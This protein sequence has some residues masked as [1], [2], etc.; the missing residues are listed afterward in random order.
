MAAHTARRWLLGGLFLVALSTALSDIVAP[1]G[2]S[3]ADPPVPVVGITVPGSP[4]IGQSVGIDITFVNGSGS[5][6]GYGPYVDLRLPM[7]AD[8]DDGLTFTDA[9]YLGATVV[10]VQ[11]V[12]DAFG[13]VTHPW[14]VDGSGPIQVCGMDPGQSFVALRLPFGSFTPGQPTATLH[15]TAQLSDEADAGT[16]L[17]VTASGGFQYGKDP[18]D[19]P[20]TDPSITGSPDSADLSPTVIRVQKRYN[21]PEGE[22]ATGPNFPRSY[23]I[24]ATI[25]RDQTVDDLILADTLPDNMQF[26]SIDTPTDP[27]SS[28]VSTPSLTVPGGTLSRNFG[29]VVGTGGTDA[30]FTFY[31]Y[32]PRLDAASADVLPPD[33]GAFDTSIDSVRADATW[34]PLDIRDD[35]GPVSAG[36]VTHTLTDKSVAIQ[37]SVRLATDIG[38]AGVSPGDTLE[39]TLRIQ[40]SDYFALR[41]VVVYDRLGDGTRWDTTAPTLTVAGNGFNSGSG[42]MD[43]DNYTV[44]AVEP[45]PSGVTPMTF[46]LS[47]ELIT[48][49]QDGR[50]V[51]GCVDPDD[52][53]A[54]PDCAPGYDDGPTEATIVFSSIVQRTY[55]DGTT[56][57]V[58]GDTLANLASVVGEVL[59]TGDFAPTGNS[60]GDGSVAV[61]SA[62]TSASIPIERGSLEKSIYAIN[63]NTS[64]PTPVHVAPGDTITYE[65]KQTFPTSRTDDFRM[66]DYLPLPIFDATTV[67]AFDP[68]F[69]DPFDPTAPPSGTAKYGPD[70]TFHAL[71]GA[72][73]PT[74]SSDATAN[75]VQFFYGDYALYPSA[76]STVD[77]LFTITVSDDPFADGLLLTNQARSQTRNSAGDLQTADAI[78]QITLDQPVLAITKGVVATSRGGA[79]LAPATTGPVT[80]STP[81]GATCPAWSDGPVTSAGL[82]AHPVDSD[83]S[84][85]DA[86]D[87][88]RFAIVVE[89]TGHSDAYEVQ[90]A[91]SLPA[92]LA[93]PGS[94]L[95]L[96]VT[97]GAGT[98]I[99]TTNIG[100]GGLLDQGIQLVDGASGALSPGVSGGTPNATGTNIVVV[101]FTLQIAGTAVPDTTISNTASLLGYANAP[102]EE[103]HLAAP[104]TDD[105]SV[106]TLAPAIGKHV[107]AA[108]MGDPDPTNVSVGEIVTY[109]TTVTIPEG[110]TPDATVTDTLPS[111][112]ALLDCVSI[113][114]SSGDVTTDLAGGFAEACNAGTNPTVGA[115]G[116]L[117]TFD[118]GTIT[119]ANADNGTPETIAIRYRTVVLNTAD[120][121]AGTPLHNSAAFSWAG[122]AIDPVSAEELVVMEPAVTVGKSADDS[123]AD[124]GDT[125]TY[126]IT[127]T[128]V[129]LPNVANAFEVAWADSVPVGET[130]VPGSLHLASGLPV[131]TISAAA[132]PDLSATWD[133]FP[134]GSSA[135]LEYQ[136]TVDATATPGDTYT[137]V[138]Q[139][140]WTSYPGDVTSPQSTFSGVSTERTGD[141]GDPGGAVNDYRA[142]DDWDVDVPLATASKSITDTDQAHTSGYNVAVGEIVTYE[143]VLTLPEGVQPLAKLTD[144][145]PAGMALVDCVSI[146]R[147]STDVSTDLVGGF[148]EACDAGTSPTV[149]A[150]GQLVTFDLGT[151][152]NANR[153]NGTAETLTLTY[154]AV[155]LN[156]G[157]NVRGQ[158]LHNSAVL[159]WTGGTAAT[160]SAPNATVVEPTMV[161]VKSAN[162]GNGDA[163]DEITFTITITNP[164]ATNGADA[165]DVVWS[166]TIPDGLT[167][168]PGSLQRTAGIVP[169]TLAASAPDLSATWDTFAQNGT[170]TLEYKATLDADVPSG[171]SYTNTATLTWTSLPGDTT[172]PLSLFS[173]VAYERTGNTGDPGGSANTYSDSDDST[174]TVNQPA[175]TKTVVTTSESGTTGT[176]RLAIG[177]IV[178]YRVVVTIPEGVT[179]NVSIRD[180]LPAGLRY[181]NDGTTKIA[182]VTNGP[183]MT[184]STLSDPT[185]PVSGNE[186]WAGHPSYVLPGAAISGGSGA[187]NDLNGFRSGD[188]PIFSLG[189]LTNADSDLDSELVVIE[190]NVLADNVVGNQSGTSLSD[191]AS[192]WAGSPAINLGN[193]AQVA[194]TIAEPIIVNVTDYAKTVTTAPTDA[195]DTIVY[196]ISVRNN[197]AATAPA[198][199]YRVLDT[200]PASVVAPSG[201]PAIVCTGGYTDSSVGSSI[202][203]TF[204]QID[205]GATCTVTITTTV[206]A[207]EPAGKTFTNTAT[208]AYTS[209]PGATGTAAGSPGNDT[210]STNPGT[211]GSATGER[212]GADGVGGL[213]DYVNTSSVSRTLA[214]PS[215]AKNTP[216]LPTAP[217][218][219]STTFDLVVT[220]P[221]GTTRGLIVTDTLPAGLI[222]V[223]YEVVKIAADSGGRL[224]ADFSGTFTTDPASETARPAGSAG[225]AWTLSFGDTVVP[226]NA[227]ANDGRFLVRITARVANIVGNQGGTVRTNGA[228]VTYTSPQTGLPVN[229]LA[230]N[231][232]RTV[233]V[234][235]PVVQIAKS[236]VSSTP[237]HDDVVTY[238][239]TISHGGGAT[240]IAAFDVS[241]VDTLPAGVAYVASSLTNT[242][243]LAPTT[244]GESGGVI[245]IT[246]ASFPLATPS[247]FTYQATVTDDTP[248]HS[249]VNAA[250]ANWTSLAGSDANE[251]TGADGPGGLNDYRASITAPLTV[252]GIDLDISK[253][254]GQTT[255]AAAQVLVYALGYHNTGNQTASGTVITDT[256]PTGT[257]FNSGSSTGTWRLA[258]DSTCPDGSAAGIVCHY[259][260]GNVA[261]GGS[262]SINFAVTVVDPIAPSQTQI[263]NTA[264]IADDGTKNADPTPSNN[265]ATDT[266]TTQ[267]ADLS[268]TKT[269]DVPRPG[270]NQ[271]IH[272]TIT[273]TNSGPDNATNVRV[274]DLLPAGIAYVSS[275]PSQGTY[276]SGTGLWNV[277]SVNNGAS[278]TLVITARATSSADATNVAEVTHSGQRDPDSTPA[279]SVPSEDDYAT[280]STDPTVADMAVTKVAGTDHPDVGSNVT[281]TIVATNNGPDD[282]TNAQVAD[283]LPAGLTFV[284]AT[285]SVGSWAG[286]TWTIGTLT[287]GSSETL[288]LVAH[289][290]DPGSITNTATV[291]ADPFD[292]VPGNNSASASISQTLDLAVTKSVDESTPNVGSTVAFT[293]RVSNSGVNAAHTVVIH[294]AL[295][296]GLTYVSDDGAGAYN[297]ATGDWT[298]GTIASAGSATLHLQA[299]VET[300]GAKTNTASVSHLDEAQTSTDNDSDSATVTPQ[301]ADV[302]LSKIVQPSDPEIGDTVQFTV[303]LVNNGPDTATNVSVHDAL[304]AGLAFSSSTPSQ[305]SYDDST[306]TWAVGALAKDAAATLVVNATVTAGG[307]HTNTATATADQYDPDP[308]NNTDDASLTSR[309]ADVGVTKTVVDD[310]TPNVGD[311]IHYSLT[312][313]NHGPDPVT[314]LVVH[315]A[316]P[317]GLT[318]VSS[319]PSQGDYVPA[320]GS[321]SI[322]NL[323]IG[324]SATMTI[325][326]RVTASGQIDNT[327]AFVS[328][329]QTDEIGANNSATATIIVPLAA[330]LAVTKVVDVSHPDV[331]GN[332]TFTIT[333]TNNGPDDATGV[334]VADALP[335]GLTFVSATPSAGTSY[336]SD[337]WTVG[338][339]DDGASASLSLVATVATP[340][341]ITNTATITG[342]Q[343]DPTPSNNT[344]SASVDQLVDLV[345]TKSVDNPAPNVG[346]AVAFTV[347]VSNAGPNTAHNVVV[348]DLLP[349][350][351]AYVSDDGAGAYSSTTGDWTVG[352]ISSGG[353]AT[354]TIGATVTTPGA[355]TNT[356]AVQAVDE[357]Q[358]STD[359]DS[360]SATVTPPEADL[361]V[362]KVVDEPRPDVGDTV[363]FTVSLT[364][365]GPDDA[366]GVALSDLLPAGLTWVS[367]DGLTAYDHTSGAW[368]IGSL[369]NDATAV[370]HISASVDVEGD[371]TNT[372][373]VADSDQYDPD[374]DNNTDDAFLTTRIADI[375]V[376]K[377]VSDPT[378][379]VGAT[380]T[381]TV[382]ITNRGPDPASQLVIHDALATGRLAFVSATPSQGDYSATTGDWTVGALAIDR[383][384]SLT[385][386]ARVID[387]GAIDNTAAVSFL[388]QRDPK[389]ENDSDTVR[390]D[391]PPAADLSLTKTADGGQLDRGSVAVFTLTVTNSGPDGTDGV[392]VH[393]AL[394]AGL[395]YVSDDGG[396]AYDSSAGNWTV[397]SLA[398]GAHATLQITV[399]VDVEGPL[400]NDAEVTA[401]RLPDPDSTPGNHASAED[402][403]ASATLDSRGVADLSLAKSVD[404]ANVVAGGQATYTLVVTNHGPDAATGVAVRDQLPDGVT[405]VGDAGGTYDPVTGTWTI[406]SLGVGE[407]ATL[408]IT[409]SVGGAG[410]ITNTAEVVASNQRDPNSTPDNGDPSE[411]DEGQA[412]IG[413]T[414]QTP[415]PTVTD[416]QAGSLGTMDPLTIWLSLLALVFFLAGMPSL[417]TV[418]VRHARQ[419]RRRG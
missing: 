386:H 337:T 97:D 405:Y 370:L 376:D 117:V 95:D 301:E 66:T 214:A 318:L 124:A 303:S 278:P 375:E 183:G 257:T 300:P 218:G 149:G 264:T 140:T 88:V 243:G 22:T 135:M 78:V 145:L 139:A 198:Y 200:L 76:A 253:S 105:A 360:D 19:N 311:T 364:N 146:V 242:A 387:S 244:F 61:A 251:R 104:L 403:Q 156:V 286:N 332:V 98:T 367:D 94:G 58:E 91:D 3:A 77:L 329:L 37:K 181:L 18:L 176:A 34:T 274:T 100:G 340:G 323:S 118:L 319:T 47:D 216:T 338:D 236:V 271:T 281:F 40:V 189:N 336:A 226:V 356:A 309:M 401:S 272:F 290:A 252:S 412:V 55:V 43:E 394:P 306:G 136:A 275:T 208:G 268:L 84:G 310:P 110:T 404:P 106:D 353:S 416:D 276:T 173:T 89:N 116:Q 390:I 203:V 250:V 5:E 155:V 343:Y 193:S 36:P 232:Q 277:G 170:S 209:L 393:D 210:G 165:F 24:T 240:D 397:G 143:V 417:R 127:I 168:V 111:G 371:Y 307:S 351:L 102:G 217:I 157:T 282:A 10:R 87:Y 8:G 346:T 223:S 90:I 188:D 67:T 395:T 219:A 305:G 260:V 325:A 334:A 352:S 132:A 30:T 17:T 415:P 46:R 296:A 256:V 160:A 241:V 348:R 69:D 342:D 73:A 299:T 333:A 14:A 357:Q 205:P 399:T 182:F 391:P 225:G 350:G 53:T 161:I 237:R 119:N 68:T 178:R 12:A 413:A 167:Y 269:V 220:L 82:A 174:V 137:N 122:G 224:T 59:D 279:N 381:Y 259:H 255:V 180:T 144:T 6:A 366:T 414:N 204:T 362:T 16:A 248:G 324:G 389:P 62:G 164:T 408:A 152:N 31:F 233:T 378:P 54:T 32:I 56:E 75:S 11:L 103:D 212:T 74:V 365:T 4:L 328:M 215:I 41:N 377:A 151:I 93:V 373:A 410:T 13:C 398:D 235:E 326:A 186:S 79:V 355:K 126:T 166:D 284:S 374:P 289:V 287:N 114:P 197:A 113:T 120:N 21:G 65:L 28:A 15:V 313:T 108:S 297:P 349:A 115:G 202:D 383:G 86:G 291:S 382:T 288:L 192:I 419:G 262:G 51:G 185:L 112:L 44:S 191:R 231:P 128:N 317:A 266:D 315:D 134:R 293:V 138:A 358:S 230:P 70:D 60:I 322:G 234:Y 33:T 125:I 409:V 169:T 52:G 396:N 107:A 347:Q 63:G 283:T 418:M 195:G 345:V 330:D 7:G 229:V 99:S 321:W 320:T 249:L 162:P 384:A 295:P 222:A 359:N 196:R 121:N 175:P 388:L 48:R 172:D 85:V 25:A 142:S 314:Q 171:S 187:P 26:L 179:P 163:G 35:D 159:S 341:P 380:I 228:R 194:Q 131:T 71:A 72:P 308:D 130:Y 96:C 38:A 369:A 147:S 298:V 245:T 406:G 354:L 123:S 49:G 27:V 9:T 81:P 133:V 312:V 379:A 411:N 150:G 141:T 177:E 207:T 148:A 211:A 190:F 39:W 201:A 199:D 80:F 154:R 368:T 23:T 45:D 335:A 221:E 261:G 2:V 213:N 254:D 339:L 385:I 361:A 265:T 83:L 294:D 400:V 247:T 42:V 363:T 238:T 246:F 344:D 158:T 239:L 101:T 57:V 270:D 304:P 273:L 372:A 109:E 302:A 29:T 263:V 184:S 331:G 327:L 392:V 153:A 292:P 20:A 64:Y 50:M 92:G 129:D 267:V 258:D 402:D 407:S 1:P 285:P 316:L 280:A 227:T 206:V